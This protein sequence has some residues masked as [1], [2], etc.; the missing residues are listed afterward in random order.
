MAR[1]RHCGPN[2]SSQEEGRRRSHTGDCKPLPL[3]PPAT[4]GGCSIITLRASR[5][6]AG[7]CI[8]CMRP[9]NCSRSRSTSCVPRPSAFRNLYHGAR[10]DFRIAHRHRRAIGRSVRLSRRPPTICRR[11]AETDAPAAEPCA[12]R[13]GQSCGRDHGRGTENIWVKYTDSPVSGEHSPYFGGSL[14][15][16]AVINAK[17][18]RFLRAPSRLGPATRR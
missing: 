10:P 9:V 12:Y 18:L 16:S 4:R 14:N 1:T 2:H 13:A 7:R 3:G 6:G 5:E 11:A 15:I 17:L 8:P